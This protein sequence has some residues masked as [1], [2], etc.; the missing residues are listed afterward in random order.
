MRGKW[1]AL[2]R[3]GY[4]DRTAAVTAVSFSVNALIG[5]GKLLLGICLLST[6]FIINAL[7]Y[8]LLCAA[9]AQALK[10]YVAARR[11]DDPCKRYE[12]EFAV[13]RHGGALLCM[14]GL[15]YLLACLY[16]YRTGKADTYSGLVVYAVATVAFTKLGF[17]IYGL[18]VSRWLKSPIV[19]TLKAIAFADAMVS[20]VVTQCVLLTMKGSPHAVESSAL[21]GMAVGLLFVA[22][23][24][25]ML[26]R[27]KR[28]PPGHEI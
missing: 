16:M 14:M 3:G 10:K 22:E 20:I 6:W 9:R 17:A 19:T 7:Y 8:L 5:A 1:F 13:F 18:K 4:P 11:I 15:T 12:E 26:C 24:L 2:C 23:G 25:V 21:F 27:K 28:M